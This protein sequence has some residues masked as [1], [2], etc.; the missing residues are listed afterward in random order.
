[1]N[2]SSI[3]L[4]LL[5]CTLV[6][7]FGRRIPLSGLRRPAVI[8]LRLAAVSLVCLASL[9]LSRRSVSEQPQYVLYLVDVSSS[10][11]ARQLGWA[12]RRISSLEAIRPAV[13][14]RALLAFGAEAK[15]LIPFGREPLSDPEAIEAALRGTDVSRE[16]TNLEAAM[17]EALRRL[18]PGRSG[19][20]VLLS[21]GAETAGDIGRLLPHLRRLGLRMFPVAVPVFGRATTIWEQLVAPPVVQRGAPV[22]LQ[23]VV[24][25]GASEPRNGQL[26]VSVSGVTIKR[27]PVR[28]Q[29]GWQVLTSSVPAIQQGALGLEVQLAIPGEGLQE[30]R[31]VY[32]QVEGPPHLLVVDDEGTAMPLLG[33]AL[34]R[35]GI[36]VSLARSV[37]LPAQPPG[38]QD[39]DGVLLFDVAKSALRAEQTEALRAY[40]ERFGGGLLVVGLGGSL[41]QELATPA[42]LDELLPV[43]YEAKGLEESQRRVCMIMLIDRSAS[44]LGARIAAAKRGAVALVKQLQPEDLVGLLA[45]DTKPYVVVEVQPAGAVRPELIDRLA[46]LRSTGG[47]D[48]FPALQAAKSRLDQT[49]ATV[50]HILLLSDGNTPFDR[51]VYQAL[52]AELRARHITVSTVG[53]GAAFINTQYLRWVADQTGGRFH[54]LRNLEELPVLIAQ[55]AQQELGKLPFTEGAFRPMRSPT[56][57]WFDD[58]ADWPLLRG[59][60]TTTPKPGA[61]V[62]VTVKAGETEDPLLARWMRGRGRVVVFTSDANTRWS[63]DWIRWPGFDA[64]WAHVARWTMR[65]DT[66]EEVFVWVDDQDGTPRVMLEGRLEEPRGT[67]TSADGTRTSPVSFVQTGR[68]RWQASVESAGSG[69]FELALDSGHDEPAGFT[70]RWIEIGTAP[71]AQELPGQLPREARLRQLAMASTAAFDAPD[72]AFVPPS[73]R[74]SGQQ[75]LLPWFLP[76]V[77]LLLLVDVALRGSSML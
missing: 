19:Q 26:S 53:V 71:A 1:M 13:M 5:A 25:S 42:R 44:M 51:R 15:T 10:M 63:P 62:D 27:Q 55:D 24:F 45:F 31:S 56:S 76:P 41:A 65:R 9:G 64:W 73:A 68:W 33:Q 28:L 67:L 54:Q 29:P 2:L 75:P 38:L 18:P 47:T 4:W 14:P 16:A 20:V 70:T 12:A 3:T 39:Y 59:Y 46:R 35:R 50:K 8:A 36:D 23:L 34:R 60:L 48:V 11:D 30:R 21:D 49:D 72:L 74:T 7:W 6:L 77:L 32:T 37:D 22:S 61:Q 57:D 40:V 58:V 52:T 43:T 69:W 17:L 66:S